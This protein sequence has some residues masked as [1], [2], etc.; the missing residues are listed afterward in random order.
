M[1]KDVVTRPEWV[2]HTGKHSRKDASDW[3]DWLDMMRKFHDRHVCFIDYLCLETTSE[4]S[5]MCKKM[6]VWKHR[7]QVMSLKTDSC[8]GANFV[9]IGV[10][11]G[12]CQFD[13]IWC[14]Q[15]WQSWH[16]DINGGASSS[17]INTL[18]SEKSCFTAYW[19]VLHPTYN[20]QAWRS[21]KDITEQLLRKIHHPNGISIVQNN[22]WACSAGPVFVHIALSFINT[23]RLS[24]EKMLIISHLTYLFIQEILILNL[25]SHKGL[26]PLVQSNRKHRTNLDYIITCFNNVYIIIFFNPIVKS[27]CFDN[28]FTP[29]AA[30]YATSTDILNSPVWF[31][32]P[33]AFTS[34]ECKTLPLSPEV[35]W[36]P[37]NV[38]ELGD[39]GGVLLHLATNEEVGE[40]G[41]ENM[42]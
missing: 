31:F 22:T 1:I 11:T 2:N 18:A 19:H 17:L 23:A 9:I 5:L 38:S 4:A 41:S 20:L 35:V 12:G 40:V 10:L 42:N 6:V 28:L 39:P 27:S 8:H 36:I 37:S 15:W 32:F 3:W 7:S 24:A 34:P 14:H 33:V 16:S 25:F 13:N 26:D 29:T 30:S 21:D